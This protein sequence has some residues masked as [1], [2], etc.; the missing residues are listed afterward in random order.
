MIWTEM[1]VYKIRTQTTW[2]MLLFP[3]PLAPVTK[4]TLWLG[5]QV[6]WE[7]HMKFSMYT[8]KRNTFS[9]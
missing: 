9:R 6:N 3:L 7:W 8:C 4:L 2:S 1:T 5:F